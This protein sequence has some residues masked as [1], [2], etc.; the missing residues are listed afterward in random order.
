MIRTQ[1][2]LESDQYEEAKLEARRLGISFAELVRRS[3][4]RALQESSGSRPWMRLAGA[5]DVDAPDASVTVDEVVY[6]GKVP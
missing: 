3:L 2:S 4:A 1:V 6:G 5:V